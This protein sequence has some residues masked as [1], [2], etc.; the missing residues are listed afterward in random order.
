MP[1]IEPNHDII[2]KESKKYDQSDQHSL[3]ISQYS[4]V[5]SN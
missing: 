5:I 1:D 3:A 2:F 4:L